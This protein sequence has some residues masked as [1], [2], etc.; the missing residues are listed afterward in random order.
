M[1]GL[2]YV[3]AGDGYSGK[4]VA[5][6]AM[7]RKNNLIIYEDVYRAATKEFGLWEQVRVDFGK[8]FY[9]LLFIQEKLREGRGDPDIAPYRQ[10]G[11]RDNHNIERIWVEMN[12][13]VTYPLKRAIIEMDNQGLINMQSDMDKFCVSEIV[14]AVAAVG[15]IRMIVAWNHH[16]IPRHG[17][18][19]V[20]QEQQNGA[21]QMHPSEIPP[22]EEA[23]RLCRQ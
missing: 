19:N 15:M 1:Y 21:I 4:I 11:S 17:I 20:L 2:T 18:P 6:S 13:Q 14:Q 3:L 9:L 22:M 12:H 7:N 10:T 23:V 16:S 8:E 5:G